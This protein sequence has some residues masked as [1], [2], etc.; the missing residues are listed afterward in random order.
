MRHATETEAAKLLITI[1]GGQTIANAAWGSGLQVQRTPPLQRNHPVKNIP[2]EFI[3]VLFT[4]KQGEATMHETKTGFVVATLAEITKPDPKADPGA[5]QQVR[6]GLAKAISDDLLVS[7]GT[8]VRD[9]AKPVPNEK[10][11]SQFAQAP[12]E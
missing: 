6:N 12:G 10:V 11:F 2:A 8:A 1:N 7:Y 3:Q 5:M 9:A 4:L